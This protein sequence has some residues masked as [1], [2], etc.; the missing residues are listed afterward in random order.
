MASS[1]STT[2]TTAG[3]PAGCT[4]S[5]ILG[6][7]INSYARDPNDYFHAALYTYLEEGCSLEAVF[8]R[9][10]MDPRGRVPVALPR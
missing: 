2:A 9:H 8:S 7:T 5:S 10:K 1:S 6:A 3:R 4:L